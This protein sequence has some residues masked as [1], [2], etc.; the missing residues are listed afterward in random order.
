MPG[1]IDT[2][3]SPALDPERFRLMDGYNEDTRMFVDG[4]VNA[5][6]DIYVTLGKVH[7][8][9]VNAE[10][11]PAWTPENRILI[12]GRA[13]QKQKERVLTR[14]AHAERDLRANI[15]HTERELSRPLTERAGMGTLN[16]EVREYVRGL[17]RPKRE[18]FMREAL[19]RDDIPTLE[20]VLGA[21]PFLSGLTAIDHEHYVRTYHTRKNPQLVRRLDLMKRF[22]DEIERNGPIVHAQFEKAVGAKPRVVEAIREANDRAEASLKIE[23]AA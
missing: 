4:V 7:D 17:D 13:S 20:A 10:G 3:V 18:A 19:E 9:R 16:G 22:L 2:R 6:N 11:N 21:Q 15:E 5:Y 12:V 8:A 23:P 1:N 14:L